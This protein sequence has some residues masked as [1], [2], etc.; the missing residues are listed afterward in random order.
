MTWLS[1]STYMLS[2]YTLVTAASRLARALGA[3]VNPL[4]LHKLASG[5]VAAVFLVCVSSFPFRVGLGSMGPYLD[6]VGSL[7][8]LLG[9]IGVAAPG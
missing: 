9:V 1:A 7:L 2:G 6:T 4:P 5:L 8:A 3:R